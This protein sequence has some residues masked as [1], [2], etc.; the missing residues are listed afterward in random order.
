MLNTHLLR[1]SDE[2]NLHILHVILRV[3]I[4]CIQPKRTHNFPRVQT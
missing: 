1:A 3:N 4:Q 2:N